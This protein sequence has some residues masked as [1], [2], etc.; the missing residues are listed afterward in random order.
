LLCILACIGIVRSLISNQQ[1]RGATGA[2]PL[3]SLVRECREEG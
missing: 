3:T 2:A 1:T